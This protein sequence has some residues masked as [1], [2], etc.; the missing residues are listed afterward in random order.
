MNFLPGLE[1]H[2]SMCIVS[3]SRKII[4]FHSNSL[5]RMQNYIPFP[6]KLEGVA[7]LIT[8]YWSKQLSTANV[9]KKKLCAE[10]IQLSV[11]KYN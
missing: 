3:N 5:I 6:F 10:Y 7:V 9:K 4:L 1:L 11:H 8:P 2:V